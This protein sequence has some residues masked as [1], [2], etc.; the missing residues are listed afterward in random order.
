MPAELLANIIRGETIESVHSGHLAIVDGERN[1]V[2]ELGEPST[3]TFLRSSAKPFQAIPFLTSGAAEAFSFAEDEVAMSIASHSGEPM[4]VDR[5]HRMLEKTGFTEADLR[6]GA[7]LPFNE[8]ARDAML[9]AGEQP[10]QLHNNCSGKHTAMLAFA[11][12]I[13]ADPANYEHRDHRIQKRII[14]CMADFAEMPEDAIA[15]AID[16]C[17]APNFALPVRAMAV[18]FANLANPLKVHTTIRSAA[19]R[20]TSAM[21]NYPELI[22]GTDRLD[23]MLMQAAPGRIVSKVGADGVWCCGVMPGTQYPTG[24]GIALKV[25][26]GDDHRGR[27]VVA[28]SILKQLGLLHSEALPALSPMAI[29]N[30][31]DETVGRV[32]AVVELNVG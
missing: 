3:V 22:A 16:G 7:H 25:A 4:H 24:L 19:S 21:M 18:A 15:L 2:A 20:A 14:R 8:A 30:R 13:D 5:V 17:A 28:V 27:P 12:H 23:T 32:E 26:D 11:K 9:R 29:K 1:T 31:R 10:T 6:C